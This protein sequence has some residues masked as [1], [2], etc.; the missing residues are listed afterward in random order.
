MKK[1]YIIKCVQTF[2]LCFA[3]AALYAQPG[4]ID[5]SFGENG[6]ILTNDLNKEHAIGVQSTGKIIRALGVHGFT[7]K[8]Y[9]EN[10][11][12]DSSFGTNGVVTTDL[13]SQL[14]QL[15]L[16]AIQP[17]DDILAL[18]EEYFEPPI[19]CR[20][21]KNGKLDSTFGTNGISTLNYTTDII[22]IMSVDVGSDGNIVLAGG[23]NNASTEPGSFIVLC[24]DSLGKQ[25]KGFG[26]NGLVATNFGHRSYA[27][28]VQIQSDGRIVAVGISN[29]SNN[30]GQNFDSVAIARYTTNGSLD[31]TFSGDGKL[32]FVQQDTQHLLFGAWSRAVKVQ[33]DKKILVSGFI[34]DA[35]S[36]GR[37]T[38]S[39]LAIWR[40]NEN[41]T[42]DSAF[43]KDGLVTLDISPYELSNALALE[44][45]GKIIVSGN[46][47]SIDLLYPKANI[48]R[49]NTDG[50]VDS[51]FG[52][53]GTLLMSFQGTPEGFEN[54]YSRGIALGKHR[55]YVDGEYMY[56]VAN[57]FLAAIRSD[58]TKSEHNGRDSTA[59]IPFAFTSFHGN[60]LDSTVQLTWQTSNERSLKPF[61]IERGKDSI[62]FS[63][64]GT[65][66]ASNTTGDH[67][68]TFTDHLSSNTT[69]TYYYRIKSLDS[70]GVT[71]YTKSLKLT[72]D[73]PSVVLPPVVDSLGSGTKV[74]V[75]PNPV[76]SQTKMLIVLA[77]SSTL[78][79]AIS[80]SL[81]HI[82]YQNHQRYPAGKSEIK[83]PFSKL[84]SGLYYIKI[85]GEAINIQHTIKK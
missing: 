1:I 75:S 85:R 56:G 44:S 81:G 10:G 32:T 65:V 37:W 68:Y 17:N 34:A 35:Q 13:Q 47:G 16:I 15:K 53:D 8:R 30:L 22:S 66:Q 21:N 78:D 3:A 38:N 2:V 61:T 28:G 54:T 71:H 43:S 67:N 79:I 40:L 70:S 45:D 58:S 83:I 72:R 14:M 59:T 11:S 41:G 74:S 20:Y 39:D 4:S 62:T 6:F 46:S 60:I 77:E 82:I 55:I 5:S 73:V 76:T 50:L 80:N 36:H 9:N 69:V 49:L 29:S 23:I 52:A 51:T 84:S 31:K 27:H 19:L 25:N 12:L 7:L 57:T 63:A 48:T 26:N 64:A 24:L 18:G 33:P 42:F